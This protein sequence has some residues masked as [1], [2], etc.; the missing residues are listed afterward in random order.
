MPRLSKSLKAGQDYPQA[1]SQFIDWFHDEASCLKYLEKMRWPEGY[2]CPRCNS[3]KSPY[4]LSRNRMMCRSCRYQ[5]TVTAGTIFEKT[6][7]PLSDWFATAWYITSQKN[8]VS[9]LG[10]KR[11]LGLGSYQTAWTILHKLRRAM[12]NPN[13]D[14]LNGVVEVDETFLGGPEAGKRSAIQYLA[15]KIPVVIAVEILEPKG[16][17]RVRL[18]RLPSASKEN[19]LPFIQE[20]IDSGTTLQTDGSTIYHTLP[21]LGYIHDKTVHLGADEPAHVSMPGVHRVASLLK[22]WLLGT[23]QGSVK[24]EH[25]DYYLDEFSFRFNRRTSKSRGLLFYRLLEQAVITDPVSYQSIKI[26][27]HNI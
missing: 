5:C 19:V 17:G 18:R 27:K 20:E 3:E 4:Q 7:V 16:F 21:D 2:I 1:W 26:N 25:L 9:A 14:K 23:F 15:K 12:V 22:R 11:V 10:L 6:R 24:S 13:R 8:G